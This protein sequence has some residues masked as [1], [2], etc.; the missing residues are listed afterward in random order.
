MDDRVE[1][2]PLAGFDSEGEPNVQRMPDGRLVVTFEFMPPSWAEDSPERFDDF[3]HQLA[4]A[5]G[6]PVDQDD[7]E[8]FLIAK[9]AADTIGRLKA[10]L[11]A[12]PR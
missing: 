10:F 6:A 5:V 8:V 2:I 12:Y 1:R 9:P 7:R 3:G 11:A 4:R